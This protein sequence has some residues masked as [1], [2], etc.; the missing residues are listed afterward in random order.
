ML[1]NALIDRCKQLAANARTEYQ[2][3]HGVPPQFEGPNQGE[4]EGYYIGDWRM[5]RREGADAADRT[6]CREIW[7]ENFFG[8]VTPSGE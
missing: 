5:L 4:F 6:R 2:S 1:S 3:D 7:Q 8:L